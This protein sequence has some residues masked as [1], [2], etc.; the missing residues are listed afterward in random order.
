MAANLGPPLTLTQPPTNVWCV[1][2]NYSEHAKEF[3]QPVPT[4]PLIFM[5]STAC[6]TQERQIPL[7]RFSDNIHHELEIAVALDENKKPTAIA[8]ALDLTARDEQDRAKQSGQPWTLAKSFSH[9]CPIS[10]WFSYQGDQWFSTLGFELKVNQQVR[11]RGQTKDMV[12]SLGHLI[13]YLDAHFP[14]QAGDIILTGTPEGVG[15]IQA[16]DQ[17]LATVGEYQWSTHF[18]R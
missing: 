2:R 16:G 1:G 10:Q 5:K 13:D 6:L 11:Q 3:N 14:L 4:R 9:S 17:L 15:P 12:F 8:L 18:T 7:P